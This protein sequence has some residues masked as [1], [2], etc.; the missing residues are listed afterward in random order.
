[1][2]CSSSSVGKITPEALYIHDSA[3]SHLSPVL[4]IFEGCARGYIGRVEGANLIKLSRREPKISYL[5]YPNFENDPH[6]ALA[7]SVTVHF[8]TFRVRFHDYR[9]RRNPPILHRKEAFL[10]PEH[11][12]HAKFARLTRIEERKGLY[13][14]PNIVGTRDGWQAI[15]VQKGLRL[16]GHRLILRR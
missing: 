4:R 13:E 6:P 12:L 11:P 15:L 14:T 10:H 9:D 7:A 1:M 3:L 8:Q 16:H 5:S 2:R